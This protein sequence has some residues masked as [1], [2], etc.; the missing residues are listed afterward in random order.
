[1][2]QLALVYKKTTYHIHFDFQLENI[3]L[4]GFSYRCRDGDEATLDHLQL[5]KEIFMNFTKQF[6]AGK[7]SIGY[8][9]DNE[10]SVRIQ[11]SL[12]NEKIKLSCEK[13]GSEYHFAIPVIDK[14]KILANLNN[15]V[16]T[17]KLEIKDQK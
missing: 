11:L 7:K 1:M 12:A 16:K 2:T 9:W 14:A 6:K 17:I 5:L 8:G 13:E 3:Q 10:D 4:S 15:I